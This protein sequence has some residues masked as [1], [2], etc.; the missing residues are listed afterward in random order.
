[1]YYRIGLCR[2]V[3]RFSFVKYVVGRSKAR[4]TKIS[5]KHLHRYVNEFAGRHNISRMDTINQMAAI[6]QAMDRKR[7]MY[8]DLIA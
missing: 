2:A 1:M 4:S 6:L 5:R 3:Q 7:R 8:K